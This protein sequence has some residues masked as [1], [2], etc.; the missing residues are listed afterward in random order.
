MHT[1]F[2]TRKAIRMKL[3]R[4]VWLGLIILL[5]LAACGGEEPLEASDD[6]LAIG[7]PERGRELYESGGAS[8]IPCTTCHTLDGTDLVGPTFQGLAARAETRVEGLSAATYVRQ[9]IVFPSAYLVAGY[10]N[11]MNVTYNQLLDEQEINDIVAYLL[12][13]TAEE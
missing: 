3:H 12:T 8:Q 7:D 9:S 5:A 6:I 11:S 10:A 2:V 4:F 1:I 13:V